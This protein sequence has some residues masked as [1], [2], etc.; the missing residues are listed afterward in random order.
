MKQFLIFF[1]L[2]LFVTGANCNEIKIILKIDK[3]IITNQDVLEEIKY[4]SLN[5]N[6]DSIDK[7]NLYN[8]AKNSII[9][10][11]I[12]KDEIEKYYNIDYEKEINS[13]RLQSI[14]NDFIS[15]SGYTDQLEF[16][17]LVKEKKLNI[18]FLKKKFVIELL[19]SINL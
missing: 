10:E 4:I 8:F 1:F 6:L 7:E 18:N 15:K 11:K 12:K 14:L 19:E 9:R 17:N 16:E 2:F 13:T 3:N 5:K